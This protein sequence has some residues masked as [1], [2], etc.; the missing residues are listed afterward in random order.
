M[1]NYKVLS[2]KVEALDP[3]EEGFIAVQVRENR[4]PLDD[5]GIPNGSSFYHRA[6]H[7]PDHDASADSPTVAAICASVHTQEWKDKYKA[8]LDAEAA[9]I[10]A[11]RLEQ[12]RVAAE[13]EATK[14]AEQEAAAIAAKEAF[15]AKVAAAVAAALESG[16]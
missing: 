7:M 10:E 9:V 14:L 13:A 8:K 4:L 2:V 3:N 11:E 6:V 15:D 5:D 16:V 12:E 1:S